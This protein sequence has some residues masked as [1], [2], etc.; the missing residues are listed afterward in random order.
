VRE[1]L[2]AVTEPVIVLIDALALLIIVIGTVEAAIGALRAVWKP[3]G[4]QRARAVFL[5]YAHW[6]VAAL[7]FQLGADIIET[8]VSTNWQTVGR[9]AAVAVI[10]TFINYFLEKD[11]ERQT[12]PPTA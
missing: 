9:V 10:R 11:L 4:E 1:W 8:S 7:T 3:L 6:L 5:R 12:P 2:D